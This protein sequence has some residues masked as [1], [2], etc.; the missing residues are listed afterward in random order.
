MNDWRRAYLYC[1]WQTWSWGQKKNHPLIYL[2]IH[3]TRARSDASLPPGL[4]QVQIRVCFFPFA[5]WYLF[6]F[7]FPIQRGDSVRQSHR[8]FVCVGEQH[9]CSSTIFWLFFTF[10]EWRE[11]FREVADTRAWLVTGADFGTGSREWWRRL[12]PPP[13]PPPP[14]PP[15]AAAQRIPT[16]RIYDRRAQVG[17]SQI[18]CPLFSLHHVRYLLWGWRHKSFLSRV[19]EKEE[20]GGRWW[21]VG[22]TLTRARTATIR[23]RLLRST[24]NH[25]RC[26][27]C[28][29]RRPPGMCVT[30]GCCCQWPVSSANMT[31]RWRQ[32]ARN[33]RSSLRNRS[34][35][36]L[37]NNYHPI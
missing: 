16:R 24:A 27:S 9:R 34:T 15:A 6:Q 23:E 19:G 29:A 37:L 2:T 25:S 33:T 22:I 10:T 18:K 7:F 14:T 35:L 20:E 31:V 13:P 17:A 26:V 3:I 28:T 1:W 12:H 11:N 5:T 30:D 32:L 36:L 21:G 8:L 4:K